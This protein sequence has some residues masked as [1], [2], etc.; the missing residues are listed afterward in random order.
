M[1]QPFPGFPAAPAF[2]QD[3]PEEPSIAACLLNNP[4]IMLHSRLKRG[5][6][7]KNAKKKKKSNKY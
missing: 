1:H 7:K 3:L 2:P 5:R 6:A 4:K